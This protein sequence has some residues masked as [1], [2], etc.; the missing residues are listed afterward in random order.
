MQFTNTGSFG[1]KH[2]RDGF[3]RGFALVVG[4]GWAY[5]FVPSMPEPP[6]DVQQDQRELEQDWRHMFGAS[7][8]EPIYLPGIH[9]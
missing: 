6:R 7:K 5:S 1:R 9:Q 3:F 4:I 8:N 2:I